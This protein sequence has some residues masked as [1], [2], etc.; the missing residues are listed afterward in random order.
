MKKK[1]L[2]LLLKTAI[3]STS[4]AAITAATC[5]EEREIKTIEYTAEELE[6]NQNLLQEITRIQEETPVFQNEE[7]FHK[8][9]IIVGK[10]TITQKD[11]LKIKELTLGYLN[12]DDLSDLKYLQ[13]LEDLT[14]IEID[15]N[16]T[17]LKYNL[18]L[19]NLA[20]NDANIRN[21]NDIPNG[22]YSIY[23]NNSRILD[24]NF[25]VPYYITDISLIKTE[26][27]NLT[28][29][30]STYLKR[31]EMQGNGFLDLKS[32]ENCTNLKEITLVSC[33][34]VRNS[35]V[36]VELSKLS[37]I[38]IDDYAPIWLTKE[39]FENSNKDNNLL[40][41]TDDIKQE[42]I[43]LDTIADTLVPDKSI[44]DAEKVEIITL[45][46]LNKLNYDPDVINKVDNYKEL[47]I[48]YNADPVT[49]TLENSTGICTSYACLF[50]A[51][52]NRVGLDTYQLFSDVHT[53]NMVKENGEYYCVDATFL[54]VDYAML[55]DGMVLEGLPN[56][57]MSFISN[58]KADLLEFYHFDLNNVYGLESDSHKYK[59]LPV[60]PLL[61]EMNR[62]YVGEDNVN[63]IITYKNKNY[64]LDTRSF[65]FKM[66]FGSIILLSTIALFHMINEEIDK[67]LEL[68]KDE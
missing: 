31:F 37:V 29:K 10:D 14:L 36:L 40:E 62:G 8:I 41:E 63:I 58:G 53:W 43:K 66:V 38:R 19:T 24:T 54:D 45:Y 60:E 27:N 47:V 9:Q 2:S 4:F 68:K 25:Y 22:V 17:D 21:T 13:N 64:I 61:E 16:G 33:P 39:I 11:L 51:L 23:F 49:T 65:Q 34:N 59:L 46:V 20:V 32:L 55:K 26:F 6:D 48:K 3:Y 52:A 15:L 30:D 57:P 35:S 67:K 1:L 7:L 50:Q 28:L 18:A 12:N 56:T 5:L 44:S 42:I